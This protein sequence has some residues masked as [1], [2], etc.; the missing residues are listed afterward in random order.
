MPGETSLHLFSGVVILFA[1]IV[2]IYL[3]LK[4]HGNLKKLC[5]VLSGFIVIHGFYHIAGFCGL[6][7]V[8]EAIL[9]P[10]SVAVLLYF[11][12]LYSG[13]VKQ[14]DLNLRKVSPAIWSPS[15]L[16]FMANTVTI[17]LLVG[18]FCLFMWLALRSRSFRSFQ[19]QTSV[20]ILIWV[21]GDI[22]SALHHTG[23]V[24]LMT[25][26]NNIGDSIHVISMIFFSSMLWLRYYYSERSSKKM[27]E[28]LDARVS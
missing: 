9:E 1:A 17:A 28:N 13:A 18:A 20:F 16:I 2:P 12:L 25:L 27:T 23:L 11:G 8:S 15:L 24:S 14:R 10:L 22:V 21:S 26:H 5:A 19:F 4:L 6:T 7:T 3:S